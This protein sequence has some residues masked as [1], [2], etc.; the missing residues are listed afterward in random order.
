MIDNVLHSKFRFFVNYPT[1]QEQVYPVNKTLEVEWA[2]DDEYRYYRRQIDTSLIFTNDTKNATTDFDS[3]YAHDRSLDGCEPLP[4]TIEKKCDDT[5]QLYYEG[6]L[7]MVDATF[8]VERCRVEVPMRPNDEWACILDQFKEEVNLFDITQRY[9]AQTVAGQIE[10][11][12]IS[13]GGDRG[14][15]TTRFDEYLTEGVERFSGDFISIDVEA[16][17]W[18]IKS[19]YG[20]D[21]DSDNNESIRERTTTYWREVLYQSS[22]PGS[23]W[24]EVESGKWARQLDTFLLIENRFESFPIFSYEVQFQTFDVEIPENGLEFEDV[25]EYLFEPCG[26]DVISDFYNINADNTAPTNEYYDKAPN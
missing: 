24:V 26:V 4:I 18:K 13:C 25:V 21:D 14:V 11:I 20:I 8:D 10:R 15:C 23:E 7:N 1:G 16:G 5:W 9:K 19:H 17:Q 6:R 2:K 12:T 22:S 3:L